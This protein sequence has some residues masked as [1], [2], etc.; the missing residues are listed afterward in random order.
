MEDR[1]QEEGEDHH[2]EGVEEHLQEG[3]VGDHLEVVV[4]DHQMGVVEVAVD[5]PVGAE[6]AGHQE[7]Q[8]QPEEMVDHWLWT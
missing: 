6:G 8:Y 1:H 3:E 7:D 5:H 4:E 2:P